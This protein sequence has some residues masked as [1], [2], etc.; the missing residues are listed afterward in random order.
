[1]DYRE[2]KNLLRRYR[3][4]TA[5]SPERAFIEAYYA[6]FETRPDVLDHLSEDEQLKLERVLFQRLQQHLQSNKPASRLRRLPVWIRYAAAVILIFGAVTYL[7]TLN[8]KTDQPV[9]D[10]YKSLQPD[11]GPGTNKAIL[12]LA[13][14]RTFN[15]DS[16]TNGEL[17][18]QGN[19]T[20]IKLSNGQ[21]VHDLSGENGKLTGGTAMLN[22]MT[23]PRGGQ[24][25][26]VL[27]D[28]TKVWLNAASSISYPPIFAGRE[29][30]VKITGEVYL[31]VSKD[32]KRPF[33]VD[34]DDRASIEVLGTSFNVNS[35]E[36]E[37]MLKTTLLEGSVKVSANQ[38]TAVLKP[39]QQAQMTSRANI[40]S[41]QSL[42]V[43]DNVDLEQV[44]AWKNGFFS[45]DNANLKQVARQLER[46]YDIEVKFE[47]KIS[48]KN[49]EGA[50]GR[51]VRLSTVLKWFSDLGINNKLEGRTLTLSGASN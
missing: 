41:D 6:A 38:K 37:A 33:I 43:A 39:G 23:T 46:W 12:T 8:K 35:Y 11:V 30:K 4:G 45:V 40:N 16:A 7:L 24:Y 28:G 49:F 29:R 15:L 32:K 3:E 21:I 34:V 20:I 13:D 18:K 9:V 47:G 36:N 31:E 19:V 1:M 2:F 10:S 26:L 27:P 51:D 44:M 42:K 25:Q 48:E 5:S 50:L 14:G 22:T 17:A